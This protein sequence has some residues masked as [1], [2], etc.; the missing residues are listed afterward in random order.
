MNGAS[1]SVI[2]A[3]YN[4]ARFITAAIESV[5]KQSHEA[6]RI[7]VVD[8][9]SKDNSLDV[10]EGLRARHAAKLSVYTHRDRENKGI[11]AT[12]LLGMSKADGTYVTVKV[13]SSFKVTGTDSG[14]GG[15]GPNGP[16]HP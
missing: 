14:F 7:I 13:D 2:V 1:I 9:G 16:P 3:S 10:I 6:D 11:A 4:G 5:L 8:D 15:P 12:Y